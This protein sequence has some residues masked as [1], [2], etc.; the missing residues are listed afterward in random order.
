MKKGFQLYHPKREEAKRG[1]VELQREV[2]A[3]V[4]EIHYLIPED[5]FD[6]WGE[7][8]IRN[9]KLSHEYAIERI[10]NYTKERRLLGEKEFRID[11]QL[12]GILNTDRKYM[13]LSEIP[14]NL[15][16]LLPPLPKAQSG[17][18]DNWCPALRS[19]KH[20][21]GQFTIAGYSWHGPIWTATC[22]R[23]NYNHSD[24]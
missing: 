19:E 24:H 10:T 21:Y 11:E 1:L 17:A 20:E 9:G 3:Q 8:N 7:E 16:H 14:E 5:Q 15:K 6:F 23:C 2:P 12:K 13:L 18:R 4:K 22:I